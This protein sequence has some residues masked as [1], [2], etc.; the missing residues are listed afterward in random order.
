MMVMHPGRP[1]GRVERRGDLGVLESLL[2]P[3]QEHL[4]LQ[5]WQPLQPRAE[6]SLGFS[7]FRPL[8][9]VA[10]PRPQLLVERDYLV[11]RGA[12]AVV[13]ED[14]AA[15]RQEPGAE[16]ALP[17]KSVH[18]P[19]RPDERHLHQVVQVGFQR[20]R[21][22]QEARQRP[23]VAPDQLSRRLL[24]SASPVWRGDSVQGAVCVYRDVTDQDLAEQALRESDERKDHFLA[25]LAHELRNPL[26]PI[27]NGVYILERTAPGGD[28]ARRA[29][30]VIDRQVHH[31]SRLVDDLLDVTRISRGKIDLQLERIDVSALVRHAAEDQRSVFA[32]RGVELEVAVGATPLQVNADPTRIA[33]VIGN[34]LHNAVKFT[35]RGG[36]VSLSAEGAGEGFAA[37]RV[38]NPSTWG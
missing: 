31:L 27:V 11:A 38:M 35:P 26:A 23:R 4:T 8:V 37:I 19:E 25:M 18:R 13:L 29:L 16:L 30:G 1:F 12:A 9:R 24:V 14:I 28:Q 36:R 3:Q 33:Q 10:V 32:D 2:R 34:L 17:P 6:P 5:P 21:P 20:P 7:R 22:R 15:D